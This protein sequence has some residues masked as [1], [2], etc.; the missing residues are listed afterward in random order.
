MSGRE[1]LL[2]TRMR[3]HVLAILAYVAGMDREAFLADAKTQDA[4]YMRIVALA[5]CVGKMRQAGPAV[6]EN[7]PEMEW[8]K[9]VGLRNRLSHEYL[10]VLPGPAWAAIQKLDSVLECIERI[11]RDMPAP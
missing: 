10:G 2:L 5:E 3:D 6:I 8:E 7:Y 1:Q 4:V 9:I 11:Q